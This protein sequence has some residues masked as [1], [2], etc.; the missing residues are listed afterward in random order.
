MKKDSATNTKWRQPILALTS[1][2]LTNTIS[3]QV[4]PNSYNGSYTDGTLLLDQ[5]SDWNSLLRT[6]IIFCVFIIIWCLLAILIPFVEYIISK[7]RYWN[8]PRYKKEQIVRA[9]IDVK[10]RVK[11]L[12]VELQ[13]GK[14]GK[15]CG[16]Y[17]VDIALCINSLYEHFSPKAMPLKKVINTAFRGSQSVE[18]IGIYVSTYEYTACLELLECMLKNVCTSFGSEDRILSSDQKK[19]EKKLEELKQEIPKL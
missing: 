7:N 19:L 8:K 11:R 4:F 12:S 18:N 2:V 13:G 6:I 14:D 17:V 9:F 5:V 16:L 15:Q 1:G 10:E 3:A